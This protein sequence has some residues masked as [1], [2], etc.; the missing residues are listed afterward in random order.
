MGTMMALI[1]L[2][3]IQGY[4]M[5]KKNTDAKYSESSMILLK[6]T[7]SLFTESN[8]FKI[9]KDLL[10]GPCLSDRHSLELL[11]QGS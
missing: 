4:H 3:R 6:K 1:A 7:D 2:L 11:A 9:L 10:K 8:N 5:N